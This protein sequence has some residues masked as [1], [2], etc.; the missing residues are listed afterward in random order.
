MRYLWQHIFTILDTYNN[1]VPLHYYLK[2]YYR[3]HPKLGSRDRRGISDAVYAWYRCGKA[4]RNDGKTREEQL[5][6]A[7]FL[8]HLPA[9]ALQKH[10]P[11]SW[12]DKWAQPVPEK[13][14]FLQ[15]AGFIIDLGLIFPADVVFSEGIRKEEWI[16]AMLRQPDLFLRI[17]KDRQRTEQLLRQQETPFHWLNEHC[18][19]LPNGA[20]IDTVLPADSY[21]IQDAS[22]QATGI[23]FDP[24]KGEEWWDCCS[25]AGGKSLL[26]K[27]TEPSVRL[28][29]TDVRETILNNLRDRF[30]QYHLTIPR[31][32]VVDAADEKSIRKALQQSRFD[33]IIS[34]V[35]CTGAGTWARTPEQL[36]FFD[37]AQIAVYA[38]RQEAILRNALDHVK[39]GGKLVYITCSVFYDENEGVVEKICA[40]K[41]FA[42]HKMQLVNGISNKADCLFAAV[43]AKQ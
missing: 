12:E 31:T 37:V 41:G 33:G 30:K 35:P 20:A 43:L 42:I 29:A 8:C 25:G 10:F 19:A 22:S 16:N 3:Q 32:L 7:L 17:R 4:F 34:D 21:V 26:L 38:Q 1:A 9:K 28:T 24:G 2:Q 6:A 18:L 40:E 5:L 15:S 14:R 39:E 36:Y 13:I 11:E 27:D 23:F